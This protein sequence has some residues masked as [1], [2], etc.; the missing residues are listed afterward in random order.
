M[1][2]AG[3]PVPT[4]CEAGLEGEER[5]LE[6]ETDSGAQPRSAHRVQAPQ[7]H[8]TQPYTGK[9]AC[10]NVL[11]LRKRHTLKAGKKGR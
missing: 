2:H 11:C 1:C 6:D 5:L 8:L 4:L 10:L 9:Q 3:D 7:F